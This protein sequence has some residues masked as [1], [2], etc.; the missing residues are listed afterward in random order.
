MKLYKD[1][2]LV[3]VNHKGY[4]EKDLQDMID[5]YQQN[6]RPTVVLPQGWNND[7]SSQIFK[8][9]PFYPQ[10][11]KSTFRPELF[12]EQNCGLNITFKEFLNYIVEED[13]KTFTFLKLS[14]Y[15]DI[16][17]QK[18]TNQS[19]SSNINVIGEIVNVVKD[20]EDQ[21]YVLED[22][23]VNTD[24][25]RS[26]GVN[27]EKGIYI[28]NSLDNIIEMIINNY[29]PSINDYIWYDFQTV[30]NIYKR[31]IQCIDFNNKYHVDMINQ[32]IDKLLSS[33]PKIINLETFILYYA[34]YLFVLIFS[35]NTLLDDF[36]ALI[37]DGIPES[38]SELNILMKDYQFNNFKIN[39]IT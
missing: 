35:N 23:T 21:E 2:K 29:K 18:Q 14:N 33:V 39:M 13:P 4:R 37:E 11:S 6:Y 26:T 32:Y 20:Y 38:V 36:I 16:K 30:M 34:M 28:T 15:N 24:E 1:D 10:I 22:Y 8:N 27:D 25:S 12:Y 5:Y 19:Y 3:Y 7:V 31:R 9:Y 17:I